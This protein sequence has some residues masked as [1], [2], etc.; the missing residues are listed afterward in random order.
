VY[1]CRRRL[2]SSGKSFIASALEERLVGA[3]TPAYRLDGDNLRHGLNANLGFSDDDRAENVRRTAHAAS[4]LAD[5]GAIAIVSLVSPIAKDRAIARRIHEEDG[6]D[7]I[8]IDVDTPVD[9]CARRDPKGLYA[10]A[11]RGEI[12]G[13]TGVDASYEPPERPEL[14]CTPGKVDVHVDRIFESLRGC[15]VVC[16]SHWPTRPDTPPVPSFC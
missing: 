3:G 14:I 6:L 13:F 15:G 7:F 5:L 11:R 2:P 8:E 9:E 12:T 4:M 10:K 1:A 16:R